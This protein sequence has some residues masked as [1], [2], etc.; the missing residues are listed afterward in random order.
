MTNLNILADRYAQ[1]KA[2]ADKA[3]KDLEAIKAEIKALGEKEIVGLHFTVT[4][5]DAPRSNISAELVREFLSPEDVALVTETKNVT[6][7][8]VKASLSAAA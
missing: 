3:T 7:I 5:T 2:A 6:T 1:I 4:V 8:R